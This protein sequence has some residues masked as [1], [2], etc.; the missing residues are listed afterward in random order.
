MFNE[1]LE[2]INDNSNLTIVPNDTQKHSGI[3]LRKLSQSSNTLSLRSV[4]SIA[5]N[6]VKSMRDIVA[7]DTSKR[8]ARIWTWELSWSFT[9]VATSSWKLDNLLFDT[10]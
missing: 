8:W 6:H 3:V 1:N 2:A 9:S 10:S 7:K 5:V 4:E